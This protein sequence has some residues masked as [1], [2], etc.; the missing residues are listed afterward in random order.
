MVLSQFRRM[1]DG[2]G[3]PETDTSRRHTRWWAGPEVLVASAAVLLDLLIPALVLVVLAIIS[4]ALR[5]E[6]PASLGLQRWHTRWLVPKMLGFAAA[7]SLF[8]LSVTM[9][10]ANHVSGTRTDLAQFADL[11]GNLGLVSSR[12]A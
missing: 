5:G 12:V 1:G 3:D 9:P 7:W 4:M 10:V 2:A 8:Q 6:G 11:E